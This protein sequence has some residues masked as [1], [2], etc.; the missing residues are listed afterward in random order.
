M[1]KLSCL[2]MVTLQVPQSDY[3]Y[4]EQFAW[5]G[6]SGCIGGCEELAPVPRGDTCCGPPSLC[7]EGLSLP[8]RPLP[9]DQVVS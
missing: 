6:V 4:G 9:G 8:G 7:M 1:A 3:L 2:C 5:I